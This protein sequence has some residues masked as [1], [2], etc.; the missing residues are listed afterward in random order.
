MKYVSI[1]LLGLGLMLPATAA[2]KPNP[3]PTP[4]AQDDLLQ[5][6]MKDF[7]PP[8]PDRP[9]ELPQVVLRTEPQSLLSNAVITAPGTLRLQIELKNKDKVAPIKTYVYQVIDVGLPLVE[10]DDKFLHQSSSP[11]D[12]SLTFTIPKG[13]RYAIVASVI[14]TYGEV[15]SARLNLFAR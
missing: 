3:T 8:K 14:T 2:P 10:L 11:K 5:G 1:F 13:G 9:Y 7:L 6:I 15:A 4:V 12:P